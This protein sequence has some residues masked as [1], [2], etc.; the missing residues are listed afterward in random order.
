MKP[1]LKGRLA[2]QIHVHF[3]VASCRL[4]LVLTEQTRQAGKNH[5][6]Q[7]PIIIIPSFPRLNCTTVTACRC[8]RRLSVGRRKNQR[9][10]SGSV[11]Q[12]KEQT[13]EED[14]QRVQTTDGTEISELTPLSSER[15]S[16]ICSQSNS[17]LQKSGKK[18]T[19][20]PKPKQLK[21]VIASSNNHLP[22]MYG[23]IIK[24]HLVPFERL[25]VVDQLHLRRN[26]VSAAGRDEHLRYGLW[27][28][29]E[30]WAS[31][32]SRSP[33]AVYVTVR[34]VSGN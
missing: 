9:S 20:T 10:G 16:K 1:R 3:L 25:S 28:I 23:W 5:A 27:Y 17:K 6:F 29:H 11:C 22:W 24:S 2:K 32:F 12:S 7:I 18:K 13:S 31:E 4:N 26:G 19:T 8:D 33:Y 34:G 30:M 14:E 21:Q 15:S